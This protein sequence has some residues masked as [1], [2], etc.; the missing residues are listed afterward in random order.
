MFAT[1]I[2]EEGLDVP[3]CNLVVKYNHVTNDIAHVQKK[4]AVVFLR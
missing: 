1:T 3:S 4:G 2:A